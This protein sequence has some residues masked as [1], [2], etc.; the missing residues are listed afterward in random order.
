[1][2]ADLPKALE[3]WKAT[4]L[5][6]LVGLETTILHLFQLFEYGLIHNVIRGLTLLGPPGIGKSFLMGKLL[7][8]API[9]CHRINCGRLLIEGSPST[10]E[11]ELRTLLYPNLDAMM[12]SAQLI[13]LE[14]LD[15]ITSS[16]NSR[17]ISLITQWLADPS[18]SNS[19]SAPT[20]ILGVTNHPT[21]IPQ[22]WKV[23]GRLSGR[24]EMRETSHLRRSNIIFE[25]L[26]KF[27]LAPDLQLRA[28]ADKLSAL[29]PSLT[30]GDLNALFCKVLV[31]GGGLAADKHWVE[32]LDGNLQPH[33]QSLDHLECQFVHALKSFVPAGWRAG[34]DRFGR[35]K[36]MT[37]SDKSVRLADLF[38][39]DE[40]V[41]E[42]QRSLLTPLRQRNS[43]MA[44]PLPVPRGILLHGPPGVG[45]TA[46]CR[47][48]C[49]VMD[50]TM[51][52]VES[53]CLRSSYVGESE[54]AIAD[55]FEHARQNAPCVLCL[56]QLDALLPPRSTLASQ[57]GSAER[58]VTSFL[59]ELDGLFAYEG[60]PVVVLLGVTN[61]PAGIDPAVLRPG[62]LDIHLQIPLP[63]RL[64]RMSILTGKLGET[65]TLSPPQLA[66]L[67]DLTEGFSG[68]DL[69]NVCQEAALATL[70][71]NLEAAEVPFEA[72]VSAIGA[73][74]EICGGIE[75]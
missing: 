66:K 8:S 58:I 22:R 72:Y 29:T 32:A 31:G 24:V 61:R 57:E 2:A 65:Q 16:F 55:L 47:A 17:A 42:L 6:E 75:N 19:N 51:V 60:G 26:H 34:L 5:K 14:D 4:L 54:I 36:P 39:L 56:D 68:A 23:S 7:A 69:E 48:L 40:I 38:G 46:L 73:Y 33:Q 71:L 67:A 9:S 59:T 64:Q 27:N 43:G 25:L 12:G 28:F 1:M 62:R 15:L 44:N 63:N 37:L 70:R 74:R 3:I 10:M 52:F 18:P 35:F 50:G 41:A 21:S 13:I 11:A 30:P 49:E 53:T 45:K 20:M